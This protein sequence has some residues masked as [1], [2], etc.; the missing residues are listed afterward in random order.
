MLPA[1]ALAAAVLAA[2]ASAAPGSHQVLYRSTG[3]GQAASAAALTLLVEHGNAQAL[4]R[5]PADGRRRPRRG[6]RA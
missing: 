2:G 1:A 5:A 3:H 4:R 6:G